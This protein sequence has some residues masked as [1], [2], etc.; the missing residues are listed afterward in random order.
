VRHPTLKHR[1]KQFQDL[2]MESDITPSET[3]SV[4]IVR[5]LKREGITYDFYTRPCSCCGEILY[6]IARTDGARI[7]CFQISE[8]KADEIE[9]VIEELHESFAIDIKVLINCLKTTMDEITSKDDFPRFLAD[10]LSNYRIRTLD[11][12]R[13]ILNRFSGEG[14]IEYLEANADSIDDDLVAAFTLGYL[15]SENWWTINHEDAIFEGYRQQE[16]REVGRPLAVDAR[17]RIGRK[18]RQAVINAARELYKKE[19][20]LRRNDSK[21]AAL[22]AQLKLPE[23]RKHDGTYLGNEAIIKHLRAARDADAL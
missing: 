9:R 11:R 23:L 22:I 14:K 18:S 7:S 15:A 20:R 3:S 21:A 17:L 13:L 4:Q 10:E 12:A 8:H 16:A 5:T 2:G 19:P 1:D 6:F